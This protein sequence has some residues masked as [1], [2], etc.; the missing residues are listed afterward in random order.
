[1]L[2][3][4]LPPDAPRD[5]AEILSEVAALPP[6]EFTL[7][8]ELLPPQLQDLAVEMHET[9]RAE[10]LRLLGDLA[11][12][13]EQD[14]LAPIIRAKK[15][16]DARMAED[17]RQ[18]Y[19][20]DRTASK[21]DRKGR[22]SDGEEQIPPGLN[23]TAARTNTW[24]ARVVNM[25][26]SGSI[27]PGNIVPTPK[28]SMDG[29]KP[30]PPAPTPAPTDP[31]AQFPSADGMLPDPRQMAGGP[32]PD[33]QFSAIDPQA[34][35][36]PDGSVLD[37]TA[38]D[39][40]A[41]YAASRMDK[42][43]KDQ[44]AEC[45]L[46]KHLRKAASDFARYGIGV[47][48]GPYE[49][50]PKRT[51]FRPVKGDG[52]TVYEATPEAEVKPIWR[53]LNPRYFFPEM[54]SDIAD[55]GFAFE[56][57]LTSKRELAELAKSPGFE[58]FADQFAELLDK[59]YKFELKGDIATNL[60]AW[61]SLSPAKEAIDGRIAV[62]RFFGHLD[63]TDIVACGCEVPTTDPLA[64]PP[65]ME[66]WF[67]DGKIL[68]ADTMVPEG[69]TRLPYYVATLFEID[70][71][72]FGGGIP[73]AMRDGQASINSLWRAAQHNTSVS[74][75]PQIGYQAG[76]AE[77]TDGDLRV[78][79]PKTWRMTK[80]GKEI[81]DAL[82]AILIP[83]HAEQYLKLLEMRIQLLDEEI[84]LPLIAQGQPDAATP[85]SSGLTMQMR[86]ASVAIL[87]VG[88]NC[89]DGWITPIFESAYHY[90]M[91][92]SKDESIKGDF[93]CVSRLV[94]D[95][96]MREIK[97]QHLL[98][99]QNMRKDDPNLDLRIKP[100][101][102]YP[103]LAV[104]LEQ[105]ADMFYTEAEA[106]VAEAEKA[107]NQPPDPKLILAQL[108]QMKAEA[109]IK[110]RDMDR[111]LDHQERMRELD[112]REKEAQS[113]DFVARTQLEIKMAELQQNG[114]QKAQDVQAKMQAEAERELTKR[115]GL[116]TADAAKQRELGANLRLEAEK[117]AQRDAENALEV[118]VEKTPR[119]A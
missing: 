63:E 103:R 38:E 33:A 11:R 87:N 119:L 96:V 72:M 46:P 108:E 4:A 105:D 43:I 78:R 32:P 112:I 44:F 90:N 56:L 10:R 47:V 111:Q 109:E 25:T 37:E 106:K 57:M 79:G 71:T 27:L 18:Y 100:D 115:A 22:A 68:R 75:G 61:N 66:I 80:E 34:A 113:R 26:S 77:P 52:F 53:R 48:C 55:A 94:S 64:G 42:L 91:V 99:L 84:N 2:D 29:R 101:I 8:L 69:S 88:Q 41:H 15:P 117:L 81:K 104:A 35:P 102:F 58:D 1:M 24:T 6:A 67:A 7:A 21:P 13:L 12:R 9:M 116:Q 83:S 45:K 17:D 16:I 23:L 3:Q 60:M 19:G 49:M 30:R 82:S 110:F 31:A 98:V 114:A 95:N 51:R 107:K 36:Q 28:P 20:L 65:L 93:D 85:T 70:D 50:R 5:P 97:A 14:K 86:A 62:W 59:D 54:V 92:N 74:A 73:Y 39:E 118:E 40:D 89:E 76:I